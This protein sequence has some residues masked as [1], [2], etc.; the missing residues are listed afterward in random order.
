MAEDGT[1]LL[2]DKSIEDKPEVE[3]PVT[4]SNNYDVLCTELARLL[5]QR[6]DLKK[7]LDR[8]NEQIN[9]VLESLK[10]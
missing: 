5:T 6:D 9:H 7:D 2:L 8:V 10:K 4:S 3:E 1:T